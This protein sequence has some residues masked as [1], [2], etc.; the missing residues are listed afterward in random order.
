M[1]QTHTYL[2]K[3]G[4]GSP[5]SLPPFVIP[6]DNDES[7]LHVGWGRSLPTWRWVAGYNASLAG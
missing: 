3:V 2:N 1:L 6:A 4:S 7:V 5:G